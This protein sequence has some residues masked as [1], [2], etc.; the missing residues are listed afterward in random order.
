[1][2]TLTVND[3]GQVTLDGDLLKHLGVAPG[4]RVTFDM[5]P[6]G[7]IEFRAARTG[8]ISDVFGM[9]KRADGPSLTIDEINEAIARGWAGD[10]S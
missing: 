6:G 1:M 8:K 10:R 2:K 3:D 4:D 9:L 5:L 7:R